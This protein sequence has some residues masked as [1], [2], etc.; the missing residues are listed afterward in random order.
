M[1]YVLSNENFKEDYAE[2]LIKSRGGDFNGM[3]NATLN[4]VEDPEKL[5]NIEK[6]VKLLFAALEQKDKTIFIIIDCDVDG[7][8]SAAIIWL[9]IKRIA[10]DI[11]LEFTVHSGKQHGLEDTIDE[12]IN[13]K[14]LSLII[15]PDASSNDYVYHH[16]LR[17]ADI[18][19]LVLDHHLAE[20]YSPDAVVINNQLSERYLNKELTGAG[21]TYQFCRYLDR[22]LNIDYANDY[23]DLAALGIISDMGSILSIENFAIINEGLNKLDKNYFFSTLIESQAYSLGDISRLDYTGISF[24]ITPL[25][26]ALIRVGTLEEKQNMFLAFV[27]GHKI[28]PSTKRGEKGL[29]E[30]IVTQVARN[31]KNAKTRQNKI[32]DA[33]MEKIAVRIFNDNLD[34]NK[35]LVVKLDEEEEDF[36][37][38]LNGLIAMNCASKYKRPTLV[39][40]ENDEGFLRGSARGLND[41]E[42]KSF[43]DYLDSTNLFEYNMGHNNAFGSS[44][45]KTILDTFIN[46]ANED[47]KD[48]NFNTDCYEVNFI[49]DIIIDNDLEYLISNISCYKRL[50]GQGNRYPLILINNI[51][52]NNNNIQIIGKNKDTLKFE[53]NNVTF[54]KFFAKDMIEDIL[55]YD[56]I[57]LEIIGEAN[58]NYYDDRI[59]PQII[60]KDYNLYD[61]SLIF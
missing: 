5:D 21:V 6:G 9:Y 34:E 46:K 61:S 37:S 35:V 49:R 38:E 27:D 26:N 42:L 48:F 58:L 57:G 56:E 29:T 1:E 23:I 18:P 25:I 7:F 51:L 28:V 24:Y 53:K 33:A 41:S 39:L 12:V 16:E 4:D 40:R 13:R 50:F 2:K 36:P 3:I 22:I 45:K 8:T 15:L 19:V 60:I 14:D 30:D 52:I 10:P 32:K 43:K 59:T 54:I 11:S 31:C 44:I 55:K 20:Y 47:L 17:T